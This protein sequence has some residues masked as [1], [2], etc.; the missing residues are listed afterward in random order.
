MLKTITALL[1]ITACFNRHQAQSIA[2]LESGGF[3]KVPFG[4]KGNSI[5]LTVEN[6]SDIEQENISITAN[7]LPDW[8]KTEKKE[9]TLGKIKAGKEMT[10]AFN[11]DVDVKA[12]AGKETTI[13]FTVK[14]KDG[15]S[16]D[17][18]INIVIPA[19][20]KYELYQ[21][22][23]NPFNPATKICYQLS[24]A[25]KV[26]IK[27]YNILGE[28]V[29]TL[30]NAMQAAGY[31]TS[32]FNGSSFSSGVYIYQIIAKGTDGKEFVKRK[33]MMILK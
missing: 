10:A 3:Y 31:Y 2:S 26:T 23:P 32:Q 6:S 20:D 16:R 30:V 28:E 25:S 17:K 5:E 19:P 18:E 9:L 11:F 29:S 7:N 21:N 4:S 27:I 12:P 33:K 15:E 1:I 8:I 22:Y 24:A 13:K 14:T